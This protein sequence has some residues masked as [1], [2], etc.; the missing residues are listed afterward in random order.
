V[1]SVPRRRRRGLA[2]G[3]LVRRMLGGFRSGKCR[4]LVRWIPR[5]VSGAGHKRRTVCRL[6]A[7][8]FR[9]L[10]RGNCRGSLAGLMGWLKCGLARRAACGRERRLVRRLCRGLSRPGRGRAIQVSGL[11]R[12]RLGGFSARVLRGVRRGR[13]RRLVRGILGRKLRGRF[14]GVVRWPRRGLERG[15]F[16][17][18]MCGFPARAEGG[19]R[20]GVPRGMV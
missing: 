15:Q 7:G 9:G 3:G 10:L 17:G 1:R 11:V 4:G 8:A 14:R 20:G 5:R 6:G 19:F 16:A 13:V 18:S 2:L 12:G